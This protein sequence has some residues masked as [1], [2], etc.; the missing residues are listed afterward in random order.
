LF[1]WDAIRANLVHADVAAITKNHLVLR[2]SQLAA[3][4]C[5]ERNNKGSML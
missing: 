5:N 3:I 1:R 4:D 2:F